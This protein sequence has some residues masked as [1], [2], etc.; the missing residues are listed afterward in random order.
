MRAKSK[1]TDRSKKWWQKLDEQKIQ[2]A[3]QEAIVDAYGDDEQ[4]TGLLTVIQDELQFPFKAKVLGEVL[5]VVGMKWPED[6]AYG[7]DLVCE[8]NGH[9][10]RIEARSVEL[11]KP[12]PQGHLCLAAYLDWK[13]RF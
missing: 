9:Q 3:L 12:L 10:Q 7:L 11:I 13:Q 1:P 6:D 4:H 2:A 5:Q 8:R